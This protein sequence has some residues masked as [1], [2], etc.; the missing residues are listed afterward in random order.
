[1]IALLLAALVVQA[2]PPTLDASV[3]QD[4]VMVGEEVTY[5]LRATSR[6]QAPMELTVAPFTGLETVSRSER[7]ELSL[8]ATATRTTVLE[9]RLRAV[10]PGRWQLGPAR[11][12]QGRD[13]VEA[14]ALVLDVSAS[15]APATAYASPHRFRAACGLIPVDQ[16]IA[17][18]SSCAATRLLT[19]WTWLSRSRLLVIAAPAARRQS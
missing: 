12:V 4:R 1:M 5:R 9:V 8:G 16:P 17:R 14:S 13:T 10:R 15:R 2:E 3:D 19:G 7:T 18:D 11:A 6:S